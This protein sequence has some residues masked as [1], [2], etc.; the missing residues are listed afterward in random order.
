MPLII[1]AANVIRRTLVA[2]PKRLSFLRKTLGDH[3][4]QQ[5]AELGVTISTP[6]TLTSR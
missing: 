5:C 6:T 1:A 2:Q 4:S 3:P